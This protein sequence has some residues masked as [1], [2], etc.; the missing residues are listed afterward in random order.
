MLTINDGNGK[1]VGMQKGPNYKEVDSNYFA[2]YNDKANKIINTVKAGYT[3]SQ[4]DEIVEAVLKGVEDYGQLSVVDAGSFNDGRRVFIKLEIEG[5]SKVGNDTIKRY[6][7]VI[8]SNDG[9]S[10]LLVGIGDFTMSCQNQFYSFPEAGRLRA[11]HTASISDKIKTLHILVGQQLEESMKMI[12]L[13]NEF[14]STKVSRNL[15]NDMVKHLLGID[16][17]MSK[18]LLEDQSSR[19]MNAMNTLYEN[20]EKEM[21]SKGN[22]LWGLH[23]G[24]TRWTTHEKSAPRRDNGRLESMTIGTNYKTN[25]ESLKFAI[26][27]LN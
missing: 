7:S 16:K 6:V 15:A 13:Y 3:V 20:I 8:D 11:R 14:Q 1:F 19:A 25:Q 23:S 9:S 27:Q 18:E 17:T 24:V 12:E 4:N 10:G 22:N 5:T 26:G 2:L 21:N